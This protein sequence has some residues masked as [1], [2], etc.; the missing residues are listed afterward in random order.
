LYPNAHVGYE[1]FQYTDSSCG[2]PSPVNVLGSI[3]NWT[4]GIVPKSTQL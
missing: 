2:P 4:L 1:N 3:I